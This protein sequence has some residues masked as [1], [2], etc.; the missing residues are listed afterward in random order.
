MQFAILSSVAYLAL[1][2]FSSLSHKRHGFRKQNTEHK[3]CFE[4]LNNFGCNKSHFKNNS[5]TYCYE[6]K[7]AFI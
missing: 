6:C 5:A 4:Y 2:Y 7:Q 3:I 1:P